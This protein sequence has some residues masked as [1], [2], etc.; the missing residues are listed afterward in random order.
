MRRV[1]GLILTAL[2]T[3]LIVLALIMRFY[4]VGQAVK[5]PLNENTITTLTA[6]N[7]SYFS[8]S[9]LAE[10]TGV[11]MT[12]TTTVQGDVAAGNS[13]RAVW[14]EFSYLYDNTNS[15]SFNYSL[16]RLAF[17]RRTAAL[18]NCCGAYVGTDTKVHFSGLGFV[19]PF[20]AQKKTYEVYDTTLMKPEPATYEGTA[21]IDGESTYKYVE[22]VPATQSGT[23]TVPGS[24]VGINDQQTVQLG[25][26]FQGTTTE[27][28]DPVTGAPVEAD[29]VQ[30]L[31]LVSPSGTQ[32]LN[33]LSAHF[34]TSPASVASAVKT[35]KSDDA[36]ISLLS[37]IL[38]VVFG[39]AG[40]LVLI[41]G[42]VLVRSRAEYEY[43][44]EDEAS[45]EGGEV[46][47]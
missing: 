16:E 34:T 46:T 11:Q 45:Y 28:V 30:H 24:L 31:Y 6:S 25:E 26:D 40:I 12:D 22:N 18:V 3:F 13:S 38:P 37:V 39:L 5:F 17:D 43:E 21:V 2:G 14:N 1:A 23:Q 29:S 20:G 10:M 9:S 36:K 4:V 8:A 32:A 41:A 47:A 33:L 44:D 19:W 15:Q 27:Y 7:V 42:I 35:A